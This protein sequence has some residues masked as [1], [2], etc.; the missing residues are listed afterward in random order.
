MRREPGYCNPPMSVCFIAQQSSV[1]G[2]RSRKASK[3]LAGVKQQQQQQYSNRV[4]GKSWFGVL[5]LWTASTISPS[6][7][8]FARGIRTNTMYQVPGI[9][10][11][12]FN[13]RHIFSWQVILNKKNG[14]RNFIK[15]EIT[16][17]AILVL[18]A[19]VFHICVLFTR[20]FIFSG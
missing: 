19:A 15:Y 20:M 13:F 17:S 16:G 2:G 5:V 10:V 14:Q 3:A 12:I 18:P 4:H 11:Q 1:H 6:V 8:A 9:L 7:F